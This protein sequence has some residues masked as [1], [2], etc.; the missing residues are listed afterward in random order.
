MTTGDKPA[1]WYRYEECRHTDGV[2]VTLREYPVLRKTPKGV[3][4]DTGFGGSRFVLR[5]AHKR[6]AC[7]TKDEA[8]ES[9]KA[10][11]RRQI[12][13]LRRQLEDA[14]KALAAAENGD[15]NRTLPKFSIWN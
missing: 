2:R 14:H 5:D 6:W 11:K 7:P 12:K 3:W 8:E 9:F 15:L 1:V 10:R 4:L 13:I